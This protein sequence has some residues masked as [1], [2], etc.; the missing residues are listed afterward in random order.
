M[1]HI[2]TALAAVATLSVA[3]QA[4][5][6]A[7]LQSSDPAANATVPAPKQLTLHFSEKLNPR[8]SG[9]ALT[10]PQMNDMAA[11]VKVS[12]GRDGMTMTATPS[13]PLGAGVYKV[14]WHAVA[15]DTHHMEGAYTFTVR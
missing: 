11:R 12:L 2:L 6:H 5:A 13:A 14:S 1:T 4:S 3:T 9:L 7:H 15:A 8:F 10:M